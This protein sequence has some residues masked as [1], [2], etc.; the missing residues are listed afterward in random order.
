M[1]LASADVYGCSFL[2]EL[3]VIFCWWVS[4]FSG[5]DRHALLL[6]GEDSS[7][8]SS[9][10]FHDIPAELHLT[11]SRSSKPE[12]ER[13]TAAILYRTLKSGHVLKK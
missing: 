5:C 11:L 8:K 1:Q 9:R 3:K 2:F 4:L 6:G 13:I 12:S 10:M 7:W